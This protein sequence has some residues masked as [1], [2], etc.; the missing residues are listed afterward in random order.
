[1]LKI[2]R[3]QGMLPPPPPPQPP[4][5]GSSQHPC[6]SEKVERPPFSYNEGQTW[7]Y[8]GFSVP[9]EEELLVVATVSA[10]QETQVGFTDINELA[11]GL[12]LL[13]KKPVYL[14]RGTT[15]GICVL[16]LSQFISQ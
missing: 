9:R 3:F 16:F 6:F 1:L 10:A 8:H 12:R 7:Y 11:R 2:K 15:C 5:G 4:T 14:T 13:S